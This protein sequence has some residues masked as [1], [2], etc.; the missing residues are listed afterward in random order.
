MT[1]DTFDGFF[2]QTPSA[3]NQAYSMVLFAQAL[4]ETGN[5]ESNLY[6]NHNNL[7]GMRPSERREK[8]YDNI[9]SS[10]QGEYASYPDRIRSVM[11]RIDLDQFNNTVP[12]RSYD[13]MTRYLEVVQSKGYATDPEYVQKV[14]QIL[15]GLA[16]GTIT[17]N[18]GGVE[19][20][21]PSGTN[22]GGLTENWFGGLF[23]DKKLFYLK[24]GLV[25]MS[26]LWL[27]RKFFRK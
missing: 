13:D 10:A 14:V 15:D 22:N 25:A 3:G 12:P 16:D 9:Y 23:A 19:N 17:P 24:I 2:N 20:E 5:F 27:W 26:G 6:I 1:F 18:T 11:D 21:N 7:F 4:H 8:L